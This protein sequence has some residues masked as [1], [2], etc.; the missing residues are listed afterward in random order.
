MRKT[1]LTCLALVFALSSWAQD[2]TV[3]GTVTSTEDGTPLPGVNVV[4]KGTTVGTTTDADGKFSLSVQGTGGSLVFSFIG[5]QTA[6]IEIGDKTV[7]D[8]SLALD[9]TQLNE[10]VVVGY[11][12]QERR[13]V[14]SSISTV[15]GSAISQLAAPSFD[16]QLAGRSA[17]VQV[18]LGSGVIGNTPTINIRGMNSIT[19]GTFP[20]VVI[21]GVPMITGNQSGVM[22]T[23]PLA[24]I[25][26][27]DVE[28]FDVL[29][30]G[31][32]TAIY[33]S[34][35]AN[36]VIL[37]TT[38][39]GS[40]SKG[41]LSVDFTV[42]TGFS[43]AVNKFDLLNAEEFVTIANEKLTNAAVAPAAFMDA[44]NTNT[45]WQD[46][47]LRKGK[48]DNYNLSLGGA[49][50]ST[51]YYF[52]LGYQEQE[53]AVEANDFDRLSFRT[54]LDHK[55]NK[56]LEVGTGI[57]ISRTNTT[58]LNTG[59]NA[60]SGNI[61]GGLRLFPNVPVYDAA[62]A[63]G[64]N[65]SPDFQVLGQGANTRAIDNNYTNQKFVLDNNKFVASTNRVLANVYGKVNIIDGLSLR[66]QYALDFLGNKD[67]QSL[68]PRH[69]D[70]RG[71]NGVV[72]QQFREVTR[73]NWQ[74]TLNYNNDFGDHGIDV[75]LGT[76]FQKTT[77][78]SF[79]A[80]GQNFSDRF[81]IDDNLIT[82]SFVTPLAGGTY[83]QNGFDSYF[84]R[85][86]YSFKDRY[87]LGFSARND[88]LSQLSEANR[89]GTF[90]GGSVGYRIS[91]EDFFKNSGISG[92]INDLK[93][94]ASYAE[95][96][97]TDIGLFPYLG[98][99]GAARYGSQNGIGFTQAGN[100][101]LEWETSKKT[102][103]GADFGLLNNKINFIFD[104]FVN[105]IDG[106]ILEVPYSPS[107]GIPNNSISQNI[108]VI[109]NS[110]ME[111]TINTTPV[112]K[113]NFSWNVSANFTTVKNEVI[114][115]YKNSA[116]LFADVPNAN[117]TGFSLAARV[118][119][120][121]NAIYGFVYAGVNPDNGNP[122]YVKG[123]GSI[124][125]RNVNTGTYSFYDPADGLNET[126]T[127]GAALNTLDVKD[128]GDRQI[129]GQV[130]PKWFGGLTNTLNYKGLS[131]E[132]FFRFSGGNHVY[133]Q[134]KQDNLVNQDFNNSGRELL[135]RWTPENPNTDV[136]RLY[137]NRSQQVNQTGNAISRF[138]EKGDF[139]RL[140]NVILSYNV[141]K[142]ILEK[143]GAFKLSNVRVFAQAQNALTFTKYTGIDP[144]LGI[145]YDNNTSPTFRTFTFGVN[146]G[147]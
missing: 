93:I 129:L 68:D 94:R 78:Q 82:G 2:R 143:T 19:S 54:N 108:G 41:K 40:K 57:N 130:L 147:L 105:N 3:T 81:F 45:D 139:L 128:G 44:N 14:S 131:L 118:G 85:I 146:V 76:E 142:S 24:D 7:I 97:N 21:D 71:S 123:D 62:N 141:P 12:V 25:N 120:S 60:L 10:V 35:A 106:Q 92:V 66:T 109:K 69:G 61:A 65:L 88:G 51:N 115:T 11:G 37:I 4:L 33:G 74:N 101:A 22:N 132:L 136:P 55:I 134:T 5:L 49:T 31:A 1:L 9:I 50:E 116:G 16:T 135:K 20:L 114:E 32:A 75:V 56:F 67:F 26:P 140:Q 58:G 87:L 122:M 145:G 83:N 127:V 119:E 125:Q 95:V 47:I 86:N 96:G 53:S 13:K 8:V 73:W 28:S 79:S 137:I 99:Y 46:V 80:T 111:F 124:V 117:R 29:K 52:S 84:G 34:R 77:F 112:N 18:T 48:F 70:G 91:E 38:K 110:G 90:F 121:I 27:A 17:G 89:K 6:E 100:Q 107:L 102:N 113:G 133:N 15:P 30:D 42:S 104:Y 59:G 126:N 138:V 36:G 63:T 39:R 72:F 144:E 43:E 98:L 23:N 64:Y 103:I